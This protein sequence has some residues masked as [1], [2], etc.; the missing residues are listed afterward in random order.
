MTGKAYQPF[1][2]DEATPFV[3]H[4][5]ENIEEP[6]ESKSITSVLSK[7]WN[8]PRA[9]AFL[10]AWC[11]VQVFTG[12][13]LP[14][15]SLLG[16][17]DLYGGGNTI[18]VSVEEFDLVTSVHSIGATVKC[19]DKGR[20]NSDDWMGGAKTDSNGNA[21]IEYDSVR[22]DNDGIWGYP[23]IA[24]TIYKQGF[25][26][27]SPPIVVN[28]DPSK[29]TNIQAMLYRDRVMLNDYGKA[30]T[31]EPDWL[32]NYGGD[33]AH[34]ISLFGECCNNHDKCYYDCQVLE[35]PDIDNNY[36]KGANFCD[37]A[38]LS[39]VSLSLYHS[40]NTFHIIF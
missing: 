38:M 10:G 33:L 17:R 35:S 15:M 32:L 36:Q 9:L 34:G 20:G 22:W 30:N 25:V 1:A 40:N 18:K 16:S 14:P 8:S 27:A 11:A 13:A 7:A 37:K 28:A 29:T 23:D 19:W 39:E 6:T 31:C 2:D 24:C 5:D 21:Y 3:N 26:P 12:V 4:G